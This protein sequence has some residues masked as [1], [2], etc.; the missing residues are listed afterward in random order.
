MAA[1]AYAMDTRVI[2]TIMCGEFS[3]MPGMR[4][5]IPQVC[6]LWT[7]TRPEA[8]AVVGSLVER[9]LLAVDDGGRVCRPQDLDD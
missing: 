6:R 1:A 7:L 8:E 4:L 9:G 2:G 3:E 5:T